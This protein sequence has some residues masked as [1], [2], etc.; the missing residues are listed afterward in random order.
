[1]VASPFSRGG[2]AFSF[3]RRESSRF[4]QRRPN[5][6][7]LSPLS[8]GSISECGVELEGRGALVPCSRGSHGIPVFSPCPYVLFSK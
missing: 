2:G 7:L 4:G 3:L 8:S 1:M 6:H 5:R